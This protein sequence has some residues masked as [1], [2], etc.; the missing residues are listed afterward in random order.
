MDTKLFRRSQAIGAI[1]VAAAYFLPWASIMSP[2]G[3]VQ[4]RGLYVDYA[5][6]LLISALLHLLLQFGRSNKETLSLTESSLKYVELAWRLVPFS[7]IAFLIWYGAKFLIAT[8]STS[9]GGPAIALGISV[10]LMMKAGLDY[11]YWIG[12][13][14]AILLV[15]SVGFLDR[16][17]TKLVTYAGVVAA[18]TVGL[19]YGFSLP[20]RHFQ[21]SGTSASS[22]SPISGSARTLPAGVSESPEQDFDS[23]P[24]VQ[25]ASVAA[26]TL[27][28]NYEASR[29]SN[30]ILISPVFR[31]VGNQAIVG[32]RG[33]LSVID[34]FGK[35][36]YA[37]DFRADDKILPGHDS[38]RGGYS[39]AENEFEDD[40]PYHKMEPL[41][42]AGTA[43]YIVTIN[44]LAFQ[45]GT[46]LPKR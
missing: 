9:S 6:V 32:V 18:V 37:F 3:S 2:V 7:L 28:K 35:E 1:L 34:G 26:R 14:G 11:G 46:V 33:R 21:Q 5:W 45:D 17:V 41:V 44:Q 40:D 27:P 13:A 16:R 38:G 36:V 43:K 12:A 10:D 23:S 39:F 8:H 4:L 42:D 24:Y 15:V 25:V 30:T 22:K 19:A 20:S 29:Y 31:N